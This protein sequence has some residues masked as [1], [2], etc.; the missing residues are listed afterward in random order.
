MLILPGNKYPKTL[1]W[2]IGFVIIGP[3]LAT[4]T[5]L[6]SLLILKVSISN[7]SKI[8][9][10]ISGITA[11]AGLGCLFDSFA[12][13]RSKAANI[14]LGISGCIIY[15]VL[16]VMMESRFHFVDNMMR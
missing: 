14:V 12:I 6:L 10:M 9:A 11:L 2:K 3:I 13:T 4:V 5:F 16:I 1:K 15:T 7:Q 8:V